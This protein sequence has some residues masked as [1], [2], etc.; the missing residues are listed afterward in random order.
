MRRIA[1]W[2]AGML[3]LG[4]SAA[5]ITVMET[6]PDVGGPG[7]GVA[8]GASGYFIV[9]RPDYRRCAAPFCGGYFVK[10]VNQPTTRCADGA[11][12]EECHVFDV[13][14]SPAGLRGAEADQF[15][16]RFGQGGGVARGTL[17]LTRDEFGNPVDTLAASES[18]RGVARSALTGE[19]YRVIDTGL[20]CVTFPCDSFGEERLNSAERRLI[21]GIDLEASGAGGAQVSR[22]LAEL[23]ATGILVAGTHRTITGP[24]GT[25]TELV[26]SEFYSRVRPRR[27]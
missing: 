25:G 18:W 8:P 16:Q 22:G 10:L 5:C 13:D 9:T 1:H 14:L 26:A 4:G 12:R 24:A 19:F 17:Q 6:R 2:L 11:Q 15:E 3:L 21:A 23:R 7:N 20:V 27:P